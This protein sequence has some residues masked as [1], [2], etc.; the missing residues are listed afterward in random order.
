MKPFR[1]ESTTPRDSTDADFR[2]ASVRRFYA[3]V[4]IVLS[5]WRSEFRGLVSGAYCAVGDNRIH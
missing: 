2:R 5:L 1:F 3:L 4:P